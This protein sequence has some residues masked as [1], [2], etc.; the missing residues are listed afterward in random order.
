VLAPPGSRSDESVGEREL[1][2]VELKV[3]FVVEFGQSRTVGMMLLQVQIVLFRLI[4]R[5]STF[6]AN[7]HLGPTFFVGVIV[8][9]SV[10][11]QSVRFE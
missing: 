3:T 5:V 7:V 10:H 6:F 8:C 1:L 4:C 11:L 2:I 9:D